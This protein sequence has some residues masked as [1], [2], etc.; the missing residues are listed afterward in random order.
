[1]ATSPLFGWEEPDDTDLVKDGAAAMRTLGNAIDTSM[2]DLLGGTSGQILSKASA[3]DMDFAWITNDIGD[4]TSVGVTSPITG[5]GTSGAVTIAIQDATTAQKGA[6]QL[7]DSTSTTSSILASTPT[8]VKSAYDLA[9]TANTAVTTNNFFAG[10][11]KIINGDFAINQR[12]FTSVTT[13]ATFG[14]DRW[15]LNLSGGTGTYS[16]QTFTVG[17]APVAG[18][19]SKNFARLAVTT[20]NDYCRLD[21]KIENVRTFAGQTVTVSFWAK[22]TN[23]ATLGSLNVTLVQ[24]F[25]TGGSPSSQVIQNFGSFTLTGSWARY[26]VTGTV[27]SISGKTIGTA[28]N[29]SIA[30][31]FGQGSNISTDSWTLDIWGVQVE[32]GSVAT[33]FQTATGTIQGELA[34]C[35]RYYVQFGGNIAFENIGNGSASSTT[36][37]II[38]LPLPVRQRSTNQTLTAASLT[39]NDGITTTA[40]SSIV[41]NSQGLDC[42]RLEAT[43]ASGL[44]QYRPYFLYANNTTAMFIGVSAEL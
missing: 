36:K 28:G 16:A 37:A 34:A 25:G 42:V 2:G 8:A 12:N 6:V 15:Y 23:P 10:K 5:G 18:Y 9:N 30:F 17:S 14:F 22:G 38:S 29:D 31:S 13:T 44:T 20:G 39:L 27:P 7:S 1:M 21:Q 26:S 41:F 35:Q 4:I 32:A 19:E 40:V 24:D 33:A 11:N 43:V 3:T